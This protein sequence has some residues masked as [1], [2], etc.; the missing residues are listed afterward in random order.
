VNILASDA[1]HIEAPN[2]LSTVFGAVR[3][4]VRQMGLTCTDD[5]EQLATAGRAAS[6]PFSFLHANQRRSSFSM[7]SQSTKF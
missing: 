1:E 5:A 7:R 6:D 4:T 3:N 2:S